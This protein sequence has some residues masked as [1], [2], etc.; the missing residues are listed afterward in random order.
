MLVEDG[1]IA[2][3]GNLKLKLYG[4]LHCASGKRMKPE[5]RIFFESEDEAIGAG[6][7]PCGHC[8]KEAY[9]RWKVG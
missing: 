5:N 2:F 9:F 6:F 3:A 4:I 7:R 1:Q 8:L